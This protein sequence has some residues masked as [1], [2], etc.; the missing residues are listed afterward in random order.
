MSRFDRIVVTWTALLVVGFAVVLVLGRPLP[1]AA[2]QL[3]AA[4][5]P[6]A[7]VSREAALQSVA[8]IVR[9]EH[10]ELGG[11]GP[12]IERREES[13]GDR[14]IV[15]VDDS[16]GGIAQGRRSTITIASGDLSVLS[17]P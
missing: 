7:P 12:T 14:W 17:Y 16:G 1:T 15:V 10:P 9:L 13:G 6:A 4:L 8:T 11:V 5:H 3:E 2:E